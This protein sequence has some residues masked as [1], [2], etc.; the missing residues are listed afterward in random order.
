MTSFSK[1]A[2]FRGVVSI[3]IC[4]FFISGCASTLALT[5]AGKKDLS[6]LQ[7]GTS[8]NRVIS[9]LGAPLSSAEQDG[10]KIDV[11]SFT[12]GYSKGAKAGRAI[13]HLAADVFTL[14]LWEIIATPTEIVFDGSERSYKVTYDKNDSIE[15]VDTLKGKPLPYSYPNIVQ[16]PVQN[17]T[18]AS[19]PT[20][21]EKI[22]NSAKPEMMSASNH[23]TE[24]SQSGSLLKAPVPVP[25]ESAIKK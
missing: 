11:Y 23:E 13:F 12:Q 7:Q 21:S 8:R 24:T 1:S 4:S 2:G 10:K 20:I 17:D 15:K 14:F 18:V 22:A 5:H 19:T 3:V 16:L 25:V 6:V 9:E